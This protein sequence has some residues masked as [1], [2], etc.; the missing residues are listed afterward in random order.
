MSRPEWPE[1]PV[2]D[3]I[4]ETPT[5][6]PSGELVDTPGYDQ[7][8]RLCYIPAPDFHLPK[9]PDDP[10]ATQITWSR[11]LLREVFDGFPFVDGAS[12]ANVIGLL[13]TPVVR[14]AIG[15]LVPLALLDAPVAGTG[16]SLV[17]EVVALV[18][19]GRYAEMLSQH[20]T[21]DEQ[22]KA[23]TAILM[24]GSPLIVMDNV[25]GR[26][27]SAALS[28]ALSA[29]VWKDRI[30]GVSENATLPNRATWM[31][32]GNNILLGGDLPRR[33][34]LIQMDPEMAHPERRS[35]FLHPDLKAWVLEERAHILTA[36]LTLARAWFAA[37]R[38]AADVPVIGGYEQWTAT[39]GG[40]LAHAGIDGFLGNLERLRDVV[41][42]SEGQWQNFLEVWYAEFGPGP[43]DAK[44][45]VTLAST[46]FDGA[47]PDDI[48]DPNSV[49]SIGWA[50]RNHQRRRYGK[51]E[52]FLVATEDRHTKQRRWRVLSGAA[53]AEG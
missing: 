33:T 3:G 7:S 24:Q 44:A 17:T 9:L 4:V 26:L 30:L 20:K 41:D 1:F 12:R 49:K 21:D 36:I 47:L 22:R 35:D 38:P 39:V 51:Q 52:L 15:G 32:T 53:G 48:K 34:Y 8:S 40:I 14:P 23:I 6:S 13:M 31:A 16:K 2:L 18:A 37:G 10:D 45:V 19:T 42:P 27:S 25:M 29:N 43:V 5:I 11:D 28:R 50:L 46:V